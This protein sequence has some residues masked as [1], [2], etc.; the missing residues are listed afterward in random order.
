MDQLD[1]SSKVIA[2][3]GAATAQTA[4]ISGHGKFP[5][6]DFQVSILSLAESP[7]QE[8]T[9]QLVYRDDHSLRVAAELKAESGEVIARAVA[10]FRDG[11]SSDTP[12]KNRGFL[13]L[14]W[15]SLEEMSA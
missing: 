3:L 15:R 14:L 12:L 7:T 2:A 10:C 1:A 9:A 8:A 13:S 4:I 6:Q 11:T 5:F